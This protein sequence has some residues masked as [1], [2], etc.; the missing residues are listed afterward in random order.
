[1]NYA[2]I[3]TATKY[4]LY[5]IELIIRVL[6]V[7]VINGY[8]ISYHKLAIKHNKQLSFIYFHMLF[9]VARHEWSVLRWILIAVKLLAFETVP[10]FLIVKITQL[11][12]IAYEWISIRFQSIT[13]IAMFTYFQ[14]SF[15]CVRVKF[16]YHLSHSKASVKGWR[17]QW[18][19]HWF[20][21]NRN[22]ILILR[23]E[24]FEF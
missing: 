23:M 18:Q 14:F 19:M 12:Q 4:L 13:K 5:S 1:M 9:A 15:N 8:W 20:Q 10:W 21:R 11:P 24:M 17:S 16:H 3:F 2:S 22:N 6:I 7:S